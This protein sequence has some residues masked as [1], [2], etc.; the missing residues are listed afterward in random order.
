M[1]GGQVLSEAKAQVGNILEITSTYTETSDVTLLAYESALP[2]N[3]AGYN[4][5]AYVDNTIE[6]LTVSVSGENPTL[7]LIEPN[8][9]IAVLN[10]SNFVQLLNTAI[11][12]VPNPASGRWTITVSSSDPYDLL[13]KGNSYLDF[14]YSVVV[15]KF[16]GH[17][18]MYPI[19][20]R[21][22]IGTTVQ[23]IISHTRTS[24]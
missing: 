14:L 15:P 19:L 13:V 16:D 8:G 20:G 21:P 4:V 2:T 17:P 18:G 23:E 11:S 5:T 7:T 9:E 6:H 22:R 12:R 10:R 1:S 24:T 3:A